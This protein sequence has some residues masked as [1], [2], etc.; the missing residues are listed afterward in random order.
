MAQGYSVKEFQ[1]Y[2]KEQ[3]EKICSDENLTYDN[4]K[5]R[6]RAFNLWIARL[7]KENNRYIDTDPEDALLGERSDLKIDLFLEDTNDNVIYLIQSEFTGTSKKSKSANVE[8]AK[9]SEFFNNH[10]N[11]NDRAWVRKYGNKRA[12]SYLSDYKKLIEDDFRF[13][14]IFI[15]TASASDRVKEVVQKANKKYEKKNINIE[16]MLYD[17]SDFKDLVSQAE[18]V[19]AKIPDFVEFYVPKDQMFIKE[20]PK[21]TVVTALKANAIEDLLRQHK[22]SLF[23]YNIRTYL[24]EKG[25][26]KDIVAT[27]EE[28]PENFFYYNNGISAVCTDLD[29]KKNKI[30]AKKFQIINGAQT[31]GALKAIEDNPNLE[32]LMRITETQSVGTE[33]GINEKIIRYNNT[34]NKITLSD[35]RSN[36]K[37]QL[38]LLNK[39]KTLNFKIFGKINYIRK[40]G[41]KMLR[42]G[43]YN[44]KLEDL[45]KIRYSYLCEPC[46]PISKAKDLWKVGDNG[47]YKKSFGINNV[48]EDIISDNQFLN[49]FLTPVVFYED[50]LE[51]CKKEAE[52]KDENRFLKRFRYHFLYF[53]GLIKKE[54]ESQGIKPASKKLVNDKEYLSNFTDPIFARIVER[55]VDLFYD[56]VEKDKY[57]NAPIRDLTMSSKHLQKL[58]NKIMSR[59]PK[60]NI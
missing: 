1:S 17:F 55:I 21:L 60:L 48:I 47:L 51:R 9:V 25:I 37:I 33:K 50:I 57:Q 53:Y 54:A 5:Q 24:G 3:V 28:E 7:Y 8:E 39:F 40:R 46:T 19:E 13:K 49:T 45:A 36:D 41:D 59:L 20:N 10:E 22:D 26:N 29:I 44:L 14:Y 27:A 31:V 16:C 43:T 58:E 2:L 34:Q 11:L 15:S 35:F 38:D 52:K 6:S 4:E 23:A 32:I 30:I 56:E 42:K 18:S 12:V